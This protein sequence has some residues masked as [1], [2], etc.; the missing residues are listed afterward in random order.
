[1]NG[2]LAPDNSGGP[3]VRAISS[4]RRVAALVLALVPVAVFA[5]PAPRIVAVGYAVPRTLPFGVAGDDGKVGYFTGEKGG[6][7]AVNLE[8]GR[9]LWKTDTDGQPLAVWDRKPVAL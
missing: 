9:V 3:M 8:T 4:A 2:P 5:A 7:E 6:L 1:M